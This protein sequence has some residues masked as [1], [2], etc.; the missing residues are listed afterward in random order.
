[1]A[2]SCGIKAT[3]SSVDNAFDAFRAKKYAL[4]KRINCI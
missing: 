4:E 1:M 3:L 2:L